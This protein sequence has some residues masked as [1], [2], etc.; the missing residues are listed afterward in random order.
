MLTDVDVRQAVEFESHEHP[1]LS[2]YLNVDPHRRSPEKYKLA[3]RSLLN[4]AKGASQA[5]KERMQNYVEMG[6]NWQGRGLIMFS[7]DAEGFWWSQ[8]L[9]VP[10]ED[11]V[12]VSFRPYVRQLATLLDTYER[13]GVIQVDQE[14][15][16]LYAFHMGVLETVEGYL[17]EEVK[18][19]KAGG[20]SSQGYQR[21]EKGVAR[22]N[23]QETAE[24]A[25]EFCRQTATRHLILAGTDKNVARFQ[26]LLSHRLRSMVVGHFSADANASASQIRDEA[27]AIAQQAEEKRSMAVADSVVTT[28]YKGGPA[29]AGLAE[30]L[31]AVQSGRALHVVAI[32]G[33]VQPAYRYVDSGYIVLSL[34]EANELGSGRIQELPDAVDSIMRRAIGQGISVTILDEH[35]GLEAIGQVAALTRY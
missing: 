4:K 23:L 35:E 6:Y 17:G 3:L 30:T 26:E 7:C 8:S 14:G 15:A 11:S 18:L 31:T 12:F 13:Y 29:V 19:H 22:Q 1:V 2:V 10:V 9:M 33:F 25:E 27:V 28:V 32:D 20:W 16:R 24:L 21:S 5:D 34:E